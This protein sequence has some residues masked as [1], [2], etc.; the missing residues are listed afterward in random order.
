MVCKSITTF[1]AMFYISNNKTFMLNTE[2][3]NLILIL[4]VEIQF[5]LVPALVKLSGLKNVWRTFVTSDKTLSL[6]WRKAHLG[7]RLTP[8]G[9]FARQRQIASSG[10][11]LQV[12]PCQT[13]WNT[14][15]IQSL[16]LWSISS[17]FSSS[18]SICPW[19]CM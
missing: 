12:V 5:N 2:K 3:T 8:Y 17:S 9:I 18:S 15:Y 13:K 6:V 4:A 10:I 7:F 14:R 19:E 11:I 1:K 16:F